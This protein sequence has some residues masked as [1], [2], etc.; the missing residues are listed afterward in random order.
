[1]KRGLWLPILLCLIFWGTA[2]A[3]DEI[4]ITPEPRAAIT[5]M[6]IDTVK[7]LHFTRTAVITLR[8]IDAD[9]K[10]VA[11]TNV[12]F[13]DVVDDETTEIDETCTDYTDLITGLGINRQFLKNAIKVKLGVE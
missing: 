9:G 7:L 5:K 12:I 8:Y 2:I 11:E 3:Q 1:M 13:M 6:V 4:E 10:Y